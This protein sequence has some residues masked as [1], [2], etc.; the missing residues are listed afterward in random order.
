MHLSIE[1]LPIVFLGVVGMGM[2]IVLIGIIR[3]A[4]HSEEHPLQN[5]LESD[6]QASNLEDLFS[7]FLQEEEKKNQDFREMVMNT[8]VH[9]RD[10]EI[11]N[12]ELSKKQSEIQQKEAIHPKVQVEKEM[13]AKIIERYK[14]GQSIEEIAK[15][16]KKGT[17]E[18][19]LII[20]LYS[21]R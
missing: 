10:K 21:M 19:K 6:G 4:G 1:N 2:A 13:F 9:K 17:G 12:S 14:Q 8:S 7:F 16:L 11:K 5:D 20:S 3:L 18:V 15:D